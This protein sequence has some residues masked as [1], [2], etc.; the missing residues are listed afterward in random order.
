M[1]SIFEKKGVDGVL[2]EIDRLGSD[3]TRRLYFTALLDVA[4][5]DSNGVKPILARV[6]QRMTTDYDRREVLEQVAARVT[7]DQSGAAAYLTAMAS[8][9]SDYD[10]R[11][12]LSALVKRH[13]A[14]VDGDAMVTAVGHMKSTYDKR[15]VLADVIGR[16]SLSL[17]SKKSVL[18][19]AAGMD[20]DYDRAE[21]LLAFVKAQGIDSV[22][23]E[24]FMSA[25]ERLK[26]SYDQD[27]VLAALA[28][29]ER[30]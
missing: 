10:Q 24:A 1:K 9:K 26:S 17:D 19:A 23:R 6:S 5:L 4:H 21:V 20:S 16:G 12:A 2:E 15:M 29:S 28:K 3:Y 18:Q 27:R 22:T 30:R 7:L 14:V 11:Q 8:M 25:A 13:G